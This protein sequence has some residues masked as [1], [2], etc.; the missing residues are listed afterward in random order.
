MFKSKG[1]TLLFLKSKNFKI[2]ELFIVNSNFFLKNKDAVIKKIYKKFKNE[3]IALRS[4]P[5]NE[6]IRM[7]YKNGRTAATMGRNKLQ[8]RKRGPYGHP[9]A[10]VTTSGRW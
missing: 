9:G 1:K 8:L 4:S 6:D 5:V 7:A 10:T 2:P 3:K